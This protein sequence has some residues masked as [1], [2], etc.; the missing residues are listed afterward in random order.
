MWYLKLINDL[1]NKPY[2]WQRRGERR[3]RRSWG[4]AVS[5]RMSWTSFVLGDDCTDLSKYYIK[6]KSQQSWRIKI[7]LVR[8]TRCIR[9]ITVFYWV[10]LLFQQLKWII[11]SK[12]IWLKIVNYYMVE[13]KKNFFLNF[14]YIAIW[15]YSSRATIF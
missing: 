3:V 7:Y 2:V 11:K 5:I 10:L 4:I 1:T 9:F 6:F 14:L 15:V 13:V 12:T 8:V